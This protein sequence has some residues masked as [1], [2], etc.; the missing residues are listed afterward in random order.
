MIILEHNEI[1]EWYREHG[2]RHEVRS[3]GVNTVIPILKEFKHQQHL[4]FNP[5]GKPRSQI[6]TVDKC[7]SAVGSWNECL[8]VL[9]LWDI[10]PS[11][12]DWPRFYAWRA[13]HLVKRSLD[14]A[15][16]HLF[17][18][19]ETSEVRE[20]LSQAFEYGWEGYVFFCNQA[21]SF[22]SI[23]FF[24]HDDWLEIRSDQKILLESGAA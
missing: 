13:K 3:D 19:N 7:L 14:T 22:D 16:G 18:Q 11:S 24:S 12:E 2:T 20:L 15:P 8:V 6:H 21:S 5:D 9:T 17:Q 1:W 10:W 4:V 23:L